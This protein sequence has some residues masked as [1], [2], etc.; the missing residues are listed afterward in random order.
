MCGIVWRGAEAAK[1]VIL[2]RFFKASVQL[3]A[4]RDGGL[5][6]PPPSCLTYFSLSHV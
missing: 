4:A 2:D 3:H 5:L 6:L 1:L